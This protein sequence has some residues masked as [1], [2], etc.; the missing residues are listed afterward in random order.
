MQNESS[1]IEELKR[2]NRH[3]LRD[4]MILHQD[5]VF[6]IC[7][8]I[9]HCQE[10]STEASQD[11]FIKAYRSIRTFDQRAKLTTWLYRI[12]YRTA[13]DYLKKRKVNRQIVLNILPH[14]GPGIENPE[15]DTDPSDLKRIVGDCLGLLDPEDAALLRL[16]YLKEMTLKEIMAITGLSISNAKIRLFRARKKLRKLLSIRG[17]NSFSQLLHE[18]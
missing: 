13:L 5:Y 16:F 17:I 1:I 3:A 6:T 12:A 14:T 9:L 10:D 2:G 7:N 4:L 18:S 15:T 8:S 11:T